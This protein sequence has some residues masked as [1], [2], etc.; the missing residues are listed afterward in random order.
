MKFRSILHGRVCVML[1]YITGAGLGNITFY[2][3]GQECG[4]IINDYPGDSASKTITC[5][6]P[7]KGTSL[8]IQKDEVE[9]LFLGE[10][11]PIFSCP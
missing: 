7:L 5:N 9:R 1:F 6:K 3:D 10:V 11:D 2:I 4:K 8:K